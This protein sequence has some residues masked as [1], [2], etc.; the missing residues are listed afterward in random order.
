MSQTSADAPA[1]LGDAMLVPL[2]VATAHAAEGEERAE[3]MASPGHMTYSRG[4]VS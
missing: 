2:W 1:Q 3:R 4:G